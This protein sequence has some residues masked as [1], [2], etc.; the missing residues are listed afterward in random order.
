M[1]VRVDEELAPAFLALVLTGPWPTL[2]EQNG[3]RRQ[4]VQQG[5]LS[6]ETVALIDIREVDL[7]RFEEVD[8]AMQAAARELAGLPKKVALVVTPGAS[9]GVGRMLQSTAP[10]GLEL[11]LFEDAEN[12]REW[13][14]H[15]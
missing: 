11:E 7:P 14:M 4:L 5:K 12:A 2:K 3:I 15:A 9:F 6:R 8:D 10:L 1:A 13:L